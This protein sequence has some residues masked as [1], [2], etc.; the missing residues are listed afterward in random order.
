MQISLKKIIFLCK[1]DNQY[2]FRLILENGYDQIIIP[3][4]KEA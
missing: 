4:H 2:I 3:L 1:G